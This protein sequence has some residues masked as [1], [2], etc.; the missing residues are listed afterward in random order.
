MKRV[1]RRKP[2]A[3]ATRIDTMVAILEREPRPLF[4]SER[5]STGELQP[6]QRIIDKALRKERNERYQTTREML[7]DL[8][9]AREQLSPGFSVTSP[10]SQASHQ[11]LENL[12]KTTARRYVWPAMI[13]AAF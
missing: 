7:G 2:F 1:P 11:A 5:Q 4:E 10:V 6:V 8:R 13:I 9:S 12:T 3:A